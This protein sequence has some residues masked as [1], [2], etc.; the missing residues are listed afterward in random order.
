MLLEWLE[1]VR[2]PGISTAQK[3]ALIEHYQTPSKLL[4]ASVQ[5]LEKFKIFSGSKKRLINRS[6][7]KQAAED[8]QTLEKISSRGLLCGFIPFNHPEFPYLL[9]QIPAPPLGIFHI[10]DHKLLDTDQI[11]IVGS[12]NA[13]PAGLKTAR[14]FSR[15]LS[16]LGFTITS[17][18]AAG[19][20][21]AAHEGALD[22]TFPT[23]A[24]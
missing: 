10:G 14:A 18:M 16:L 13:S 12:R 5:S 19:I 23:A 20:D 7:K 1:L 11:A 2:L 3:R 4:N 24:E 9:N 15:E 6:F 17:G 22:S 21:T 8:F